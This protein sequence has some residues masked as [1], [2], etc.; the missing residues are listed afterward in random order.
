[1]PDAR[2]LRGLAIVGNL[3][4]LLAVSGVDDRTL[5][6]LLYIGC[7][8]HKVLSSERREGA[9]RGI[10]ERPIDR[11]PIQPVVSVLLSG[12]S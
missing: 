4:V 6:L 2:G 12:L 5:L 9:R 3:M 7:V 8:V 1:V 11:T 10:G